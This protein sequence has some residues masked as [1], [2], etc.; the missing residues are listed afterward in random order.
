[1]LGAVFAPLSLAQKTRE[2]DSKIA[3]FKIN[4]SNQ[5]KSYEKI[6][7]LIANNASFAEHYDLDNALAK[8]NKL[9]EYVKAEKIKNDI[10]SSLPTYE[11]YLKLFESIPVILNKIRDME[12]MDKLLRYFFSNFT[13]KPTNETDFKESKVSAELKEPWRGF[14]D[15]DDFVRGAGTGTL[16]L[17]LVLGKDAL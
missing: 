3:S 16:T 1:V 11:E 17:D 6:K 9:S 14:L 10:K 15:N 2:Y 7:D 5:E 13:I 8:V 4:I 12:A